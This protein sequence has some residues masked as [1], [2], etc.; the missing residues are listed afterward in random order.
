MASKSKVVRQQAIKKSNRDNFYLVAIPLLAFVIKLI[1]MA[2]ITGGGWLG[3]D[4]ESWLAGADGLLK[5]GYYSDASV[6]SY[7]P[8]GYPIIIWLIAKI[9]VV[10]G[11]WLLSLVQSAF[12]AYASYFFVKQLRDTKLRPY[13]LLIGIAIAFNPTL[14][15][16]TLVVG[17]ES[18]LS[19][20][21]LLIVGFIIKSKNMAA[22]AKIGKFIVGVGA[23]SALATFIQP[24]WILTTII[25]AIAW[26][27]M[28]KNRKIQAVIL[29]GVI[30]I[31]SIAP[32]LIVQRNIQ[33]VD[34]AVVASILGGNMAVGAG[35][36]TSGGYPHTGPVVPC[37]PTPPAAAVTDSEMFRCVI[38][39]YAG[40]PV[41]GVRLFINKGFFYWSPWSGPLGEGTMAR[42]PWLKVNPL[43]N[44]AKGS[45]E[46]SDFI[47]K[48]PGKIIS[49]AWVMGCISLMFV[50]FFWLRS[51]KGLYAN[52]AYM[53]LTPVV[54]SWL[55][56]LA[57]VGDH[58]Y[59]IPTMP[60][61]LF[62]QV[63]GYFA[64]RH[65]AKTRSFAITLEP[66]AKAR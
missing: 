62:L 45:Q 37:E 43:I 23:I 55:V 27:L 20:S 16:S 39:W 60:L 30:G 34:K 51:M 53:T 42:N 2:N 26:A 50:G 22:D 11:V 64:L 1:T 8:A 48:L 10:N 63:M 21:M 28:F 6:L 35:D 40:H 15:L 49:F 31:M 46:G 56:T 65:K 3:S 12:Y 47:N 33:S 59:R 17:Y 29:I 4:G 24:R 57:T 19:T 32:A 61:S 54:V 52:I 44:I 9:S 13:I 18:L 58:R 36:E 7:L 5:Q 38:K 14:S 66:S 25:I 41:K